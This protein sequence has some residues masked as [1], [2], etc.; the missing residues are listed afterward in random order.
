MEEQNAYDEEF[1]QAKIIAI[2]KTAKAIK[3]IYT[4]LMLIFIAAL[5]YSGITI[6]KAFIKGGTA[7]MSAEQPPEP[8][9][10]PKNV[11]TPDTWRWLRLGYQN[12]QPVSIH[13]IKA[14]KNG[15]PLP[16]S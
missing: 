6:G 3:K 7:V 11:K 1:Q 14:R 2:S 5:I 4:I 15:K 12:A 16:S 10:I 8:C 9:I 13:R